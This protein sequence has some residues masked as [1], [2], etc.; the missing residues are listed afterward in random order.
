MASF[1]MVPFA[2]PMVDGRFAFRERTYQLAHNFPGRRVALHGD[3]WQHAWRVQRAG[4][5]TATIRY[6]Q[7]GARFPF[8]YTAEQAFALGADRLTVRLT[9]RNTG[10]KP[11]PAGIGFHPFFPKEPDARLQTAARRLWR[12]NGNGS[13]ENLES[14]PRA[15]SFSKS[16]SVQGL[17]INH[18]YAG[19]RRR[20][21]IRWPVRGLDIVLT[22]RPPLDS[23][24]LFIPAERDC[25]CVEPVSNS[26][27]GFN[28]LALGLPHSGV[29]T[30]EPG[31]EISGS[32]TLQVKSTSRSGKSR[33]R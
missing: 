21:V 25:F 3:G 12:R 10:R 20:A 19:W 8:R 33:R 23:L 15:L 5:S 14:V 24:V 22:A 4:K 2:G 18:A 28:R 11:M 26:P 27:D 32:M 6:R 9:L 7:T 16:R 13:V 17:D 30:L 31:E 29:R 1:P